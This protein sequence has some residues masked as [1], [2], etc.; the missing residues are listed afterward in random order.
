MNQKRR[1]KCPRAAAGLTLIACLGAFLAPSAHALPEDREQPIYIES[2]RAER[3]GLNGVTTYEGDVRLRQGSLNIRA[4]RLT[5]HTGE[6]NQV[7]RV[8]AE[9]SPAHFE[10]KP[11]AEDPPIAAQALT[12]RYEVDREQLKLLRNAWMEQG[13]ATM[14]GNRIDYDIASEVLK[15]EGDSDSERPRIEMV[16]PPQNDRSSQD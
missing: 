16:L 5:V 13:E 10:Q 6:D 4:E 8:I 1:I 15:A 9:G 12:I 14:S 2:D 3:D 11:N 7:K